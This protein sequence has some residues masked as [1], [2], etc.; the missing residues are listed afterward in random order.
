MPS[1]RHAL[2]T[3]A[4]SALFGGLF[5]LAALWLRYEDARGDME[6]D[7]RRSSVYLQVLGF[8]LFNVVTTLKS[9]E[10]GATYADGGLCAADGLAFLRQ[11]EFSTLLFSD[12]AIVENG[13]V[14]CSTS[15]GQTARGKT[16]PETSTPVTFSGIDA[17]IA[18]YTEDESFVD[19]RIRGSYFGFN[20]FLMTLDDRPLF[21]AD[22]G[23]TSLT[24]L[25]RQDRTFTPVF[26]DTLES[27]DDSTLTAR[28]LQDDPLSDLFCLDQSN[29]C[30]YGARPAFA[31]FAD[32]GVLL[33]LAL[34]F[35]GVTGT[36]T[37]VAMRRYVKRQSTLQQKLRRA[38]ADGK[39]YVEYQPIIDMG[40]G[41]VR[42][43]EALVRWTD[44][45]GQKIRPDIFIAIAEE[46]NF[47]D[48]ITDYVLRYTAKH[49]WSCPT[50]KDVK[51][52]FNVSPVEILAPDFVERYNALFAECG[53]DKRNVRI[54]ITER[55]Q[56]D[57]VEFEAAIDVIS[58]AGFAIALDDFGTGHAS[59]PYLRRLPLDAIKLDKSFVDA[60]GEET[61][62]GRMLPHLIDMIKA[63]DIAV[64]IEGIEETNQKEWFMDKGSM[65]AQGYF[66]SR[67][68]DVGAFESY[69]EE[70][71][72]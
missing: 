34:V 66:Y 29:L 49:F 8:E 54:E 20:G 63:L 24:Y 11:L 47:T 21:A 65:F 57:L 59:F 32:A 64:I 16:L 52:A 71:H 46:A 5:F 2:S 69:A 35:G 18:Y 9:S 51:V 4:T 28:R 68:L 38:I 26:G 39:L 58:A 37:T 3:L 27:A 48:E 1:L 33:G 67:P 14:A 44:D 25:I 40:D 7:V 45:D 23:D 12:I 19:P 53:I 61:A 43:A 17:P 70:L 41:T 36:G 10:N 55:V 15:L 50:L 56:V 42:S 6:D 60:L 72:S 13:A 62:Y 30:V 31:P 22:T